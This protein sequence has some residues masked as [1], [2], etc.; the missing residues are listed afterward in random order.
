MVKKC[1]ELMLSGLSFSIQ[2]ECFG[3]A[4]HDKSL[5]LID[6]ITYLRVTSSA[7]RSEVPAR[8]PEAK[9]YKL[10]YVI[11]LIFPL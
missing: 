7:E 2:F 11:F 5:E 8:M 6:Y 3:S 1:W 10:Q 9:P 4:Q